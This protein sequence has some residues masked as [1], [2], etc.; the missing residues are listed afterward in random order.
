M[1][2]EEMNYEEIEKALFQ[3]HNELRTKPQNFTK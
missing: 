3:L 1:S 2:V